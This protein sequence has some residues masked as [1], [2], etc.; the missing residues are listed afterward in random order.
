MKTIYHISDI[1]IRNQDRHEEYRQVFKNLR[2]EIK[3]ETNEKIIV[4]TGD[5][6]HE[7]CNLSPESIILFK[8]FISRLNKLG[9]IIIIDGNHDVNINNDKRKSGICASLK[10]LNTSG[11]IHY[12]HSENLSVKI[13]NINFILTVMDKKVLKIENKNDGEIYIGLY[14]GTLYK[15]RIDN[16]YEIDNDKY[17]KASDFEEY[18]IVMLGDIHKHQFMNKEKTIA[19]ASSL[20]QQNYGESVDKHG[21]IKWDIEKKQGHFIE[22]YNDIGYIKCNLTKDGFKILGDIKSK[23]KLHVEI[24]YETDMRDNIEEELKKI[25]EKYEIL[26][27]RYNE[28]K[29]VKKNENHGEEKLNKNIIEIYKELMNKHEQEEDK[30]VIDILEKH[31][32][33]K[34]NNREIKLIKMEFEN[35]FSYGNK[36]IVDFSNMDGIITII[37]DNGAGKSSIIDALLFCL[38]DEFSKGSGREA[39]NISKNSGYCYLHISVNNV[40]YRIERKI[41]KTKSEVR[42]F[43]DDENISN[44][45]KKNTD[46]D[47]IEI[48]GDYVLLNSICISLQDGINLLNTNDNHKMKM[49]Y[50]LLNINQYEEI[51]TETDFK[52]NKLSRNMSAVQKEIDKL[53][54]ILQNEKAIQEKL[55]L[56]ND[57]INNLE[58]KLTIE[59]KEINNLEYELEKI[60]EKNF[61][62]INSKI[63]E[64][65]NK[66]KEKELKIIKNKQMCNNME[67]INLELEKIILGK[68]NSVEKIIDIVKIEQELNNRITDIGKLNID[69]MKN[70]NKEYVETNSVLNLEK[71]EYSDKIKNYTV[72]ENYISEHDENILESFENDYITEENIRNKYIEKINNNE[73]EN[74]EILKKK[75]ILKKI[76]VDTK[77]EFDQFEQ[78]KKIIPFYNYI[79]NLSFEKK[80]LKCNENKN[81]IKN[82]DIVKNIDNIDNKQEELIKI[83]K[84]NE[85]DII[86]LDNRYEMNNKNIYT[87]RLNIEEEINNLKIKIIQ[88]QQYGKNKIQQEKLK[89]EYELIKIER[90]IQ[91][92]IE[93]KNKRDEYEINKKIIRMDIEEKI[94]ECEY[95]I[96]ELNE[97]KN[98]Y[99]LII[100]NRKIDTIINDKKKERDTI[101]KEIECVIKINSE[102]DTLL[103]EKEILYNIE[104]QQN[105]YKIMKNKS[106]EL[107]ITSN[108][109]KKELKK[110]IVVRD[111]LNKLIGEITITTKI[112]EDKKEILINIQKEYDTVIKIIDLYG[113]YEMMNYILNKYIVRL[114]QII[115]NILMTIVPYKIKIIQENTELRIYK[116]ENNITINTRQLSGNEKFVINIAFKCALNKM[117]ISYKSDFI[118]IDEGFGSFDSDKLNKISE[119]FDVLKKEFNKC[120]IISHLDKI[121]NMNNRVLRVSRDE[122]GY[123]KIN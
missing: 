76:I 17:I 122:N 39:L 23:S 74:E 8:E 43:K 4:I 1:H 83:I 92:E 117:A 102:Y 49:F 44:N 26:S 46:R 29:I 58:I 12:L 89:K 105:M 48:V 31:V 88:K 108:E 106:N 80:C 11:I 20:I 77:E 25:K 55:I 24:N 72:Y 99:I 84:K 6:F 112:Y 59:V 79:N 15:S 18:D 114:E 111:D 53:M 62:L 5:V 95:N 32:I 50:N 19:Y 65:V 28:I 78:N 9:T 73:I 34:T 119:L 37:G 14:H 100:H 64:C 69:L 107:I 81:I 38:Y 60:D 103:K 30:N 110:L 33:T 113:K 116:L 68:N 61:H 35:L 7:K 56:N 63:L 85:N 86:L 90:T 3:K 21:I 57:S 98:D 41:T 22:I 115:N 75:D 120:I 70:K 104:K 16:G 10:R 71:D 42:L 45:N 47:I 13:D 96:K 2:N 123:S 54:L 109:T 67:K 36:S 51:K 94:K 101:L 27:Y 91:Y 121:K 52:K 66:I 93:K 40:N 97:I 82:L 118:I 87:Y